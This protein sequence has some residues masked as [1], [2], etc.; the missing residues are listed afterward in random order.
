MNV[1]LANWR[2]GNLENYGESNDCTELS[3]EFIPL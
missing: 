1:A 2:V 3:V